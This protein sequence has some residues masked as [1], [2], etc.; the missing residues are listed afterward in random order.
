MTLQQ[1]LNEVY[2]LGFEDIGQIDDN[3]IAVCKYIDSVV[4]DLIG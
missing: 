3:F 2:C 4:K 1:L